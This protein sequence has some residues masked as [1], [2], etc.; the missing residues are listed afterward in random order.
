MIAS[1]TSPSTNATGVFRDSSRR[2]LRCGQELRLLKQIETFAPHAQ[3]EVDE[4]DGD[5]DDGVD[6]GVDDDA[7]RSGDPQKA[8]KFVLKTGRLFPRAGW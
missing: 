7:R 3:V 5:L 4:D 8:S 6:Q 2:G 1:E